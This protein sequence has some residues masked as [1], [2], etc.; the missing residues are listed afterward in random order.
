MLDKATYKE[1]HLGKEWFWD[2]KYHREDGPAII[3]HN[4]YKAW[5]IKGKRHRADGPAVEWKNGTKE[6][7]LYGI[8][9]RNDGPAKEWPD[10]TKEWYLNGKLHR[11]DG[12]AIEWKNIHLWALDNKSYKKQEYFEELEKK[13]G[14]EYANK[15]R[16]IYV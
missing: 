1:H 4:G 10:G 8:L 12:P 5:Y 7:Y 11:E 13:Y 2:G 3:W 14:K 16:L 15:L 9:H 6:W